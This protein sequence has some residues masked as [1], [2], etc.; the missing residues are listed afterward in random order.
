MPLITDYS[1]PTI[2]SPES[3]IRSVRPPL[4]SQLAGSSR[5]LLYP[6]NTLLSDCGF[7]FGSS[8]AVEENLDRVASVSA[9]R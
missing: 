9:I 1:N 5:I 3:G 8:P 4:K 6:V 7:F 2:V